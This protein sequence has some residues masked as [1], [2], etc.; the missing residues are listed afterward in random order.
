M[1]RK[2]GVQR[3]FYRKDEG[4]DLLIDEMKV[5]ESLRDD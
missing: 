2:I 1:R 3:A 5:L 4:D